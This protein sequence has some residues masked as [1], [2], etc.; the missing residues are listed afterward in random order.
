[1]LDGGGGGGVR[2]AFQVEQEKNAV[3]NEKSDVEQ[4]KST[5][6]QVAIVDLVRSSI[7]HLFFQELVRV[8]QE[9]IDVENERDSK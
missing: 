2:C 9:K 5:L 7:S 3:H 4:D 1:M 6:R 8:E